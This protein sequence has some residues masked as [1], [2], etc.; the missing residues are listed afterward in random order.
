MTDLHSNT[1][2]QDE[3]VAPKI[4]ELLSS[5]LARVGPERQHRDECLLV[6]PKTLNPIWLLNSAH[7]QVQEG[8]TAD[9]SFV[10]LQFADNDTHKLYTTDLKLQDILRLI[11]QKTTEMEARSIFKEV[12]FD[13]AAAAAAAGSSKK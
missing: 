4:I 9:R 7:V 2:E 12:N 5:C 6:F 8:S 13:P 10:E 3:I 1:V 11:Q